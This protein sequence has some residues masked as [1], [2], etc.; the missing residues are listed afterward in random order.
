[1]EVL[2]TD[3]TAEP[4]HLQGELDPQDFDIEEVTQIKA[5]LPI[6]YDL[7]AQLLGLEFLVKGSLTFDVGMDCVRCGEFFSTTL[8]DSAFLRAFEVSDITDYVDLAPDMRDSVLL[9]LPNFPLCSSEC[10]G[11]CSVCGTNLNTGSCACVAP[12]VEGVWGGLD[13]LDIKRDD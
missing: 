7:R 9:S 6:R 10:K 1:M 8:H 2:I 11:L 4:K 13:V 5:I 3:Y 12:A